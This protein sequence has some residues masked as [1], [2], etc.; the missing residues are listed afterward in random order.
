MI[1]GLRMGPSLVEINIQQ[2]DVHGTVEFL[3]IHVINGLLQNVTNE[4]EIRHQE[5][6]P[7]RPL[8]EALFEALKFDQ[9][10]TNVLL[11]TSVMTLAT[12]RGLEWD[13]LQ[14]LVD[15]GQAQ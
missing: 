14:A 11:R 5:N 6:S 1:W 8:C 9:Q 13:D 2:E 12:A 7:H 15:R 4:V 3:N 10:Q